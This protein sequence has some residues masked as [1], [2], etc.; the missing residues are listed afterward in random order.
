VIGQVQETV[1]TLRRSALRLA[2]EYEGHDEHRP[3]RGY[4]KALASYATAVVGFAA[5]GRRAGWQ[6]P[7]R[8]PVSDMA[9]L[10]VMTFRVSRLLTKSAVASPLRAPFTT[11]KGSGG[12]GEVLEEVRENGDLHAVGELLTCPFCLAQWI[13]TTSIAAYVAAPRQTRLAATAMTLATA[14][15]VLQIAYDDLRN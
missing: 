1:S 14:S 11:F 5:L 4:T 9:L 15:D 3:L 7:D 10:A 2:A 13:A 8:V 6:I 12:T